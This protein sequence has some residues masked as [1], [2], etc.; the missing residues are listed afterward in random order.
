MTAEII[1]SAFNDIG[2]HAF[3][4]GSKD[5]A[6]GLDFLMTQHNNANFPYVS[7]N[8]ANKTNKLLF[9]SADDSIF[10]DKFLPLNSGEIFILISA[11]LSCIL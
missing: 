1:I 7:C 11:D 3:S 5:F 2:C 6:A 4:P 9:K 10:T 8:I